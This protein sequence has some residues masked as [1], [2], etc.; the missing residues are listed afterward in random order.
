[1]R[2]NTAADATT[3][4]YVVDM[5]ATVARR[6]KVRRETEKL[7]QLMVNFFGPGNGSRPPDP[8]WLRTLFSH[9]PRN[10]GAEGAWH[11]SNALLGDDSVYL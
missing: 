8:Q 2:S 10:W 3:L 7:D 1:M 11:P 5:H 6:Y 9:R 4:R